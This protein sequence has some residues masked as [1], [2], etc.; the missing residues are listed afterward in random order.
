MIFNRF[1]IGSEVIWDK[2]VELVIFKE[3]CFVYLWIFSFLGLDG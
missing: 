2:G 1:F 3:N